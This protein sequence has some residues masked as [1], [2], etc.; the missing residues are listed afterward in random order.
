MRFLRTS[1]Q[2]LNKL[3]TEWEVYEEARS[4]MAAMLEIIP[5]MKNRSEFVCTRN[6]VE[7][8]LSACPPSH[9]KLLKE[10]A[11][12][13]KECISAVMRKRGFEPI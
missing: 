3:Q 7:A 10:R 6:R 1:R 13:T 4:E 2:R 5:H 12:L 8:L 11:D 9:R